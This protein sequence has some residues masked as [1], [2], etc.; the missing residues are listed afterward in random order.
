MKKECYLIVKLSITFLIKIKRTLPLN[1]GK[2]QNREYLLI[3]RRTPIAINI[4]VNEE[5][6]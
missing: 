2:V 1:R 5:P 3:L 4:N 6:P